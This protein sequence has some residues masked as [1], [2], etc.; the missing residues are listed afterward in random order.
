MS[1]WGI[2]RSFNVVM[3]AFWTSMLISSSDNSHFHPGS[4]KLLLW[5]HQ[6]QDYPQLIAHISKS[7][8]TADR[9]LNKGLPDLAM[10][11][12]VLLC[13]SKSIV[14]EFLY[15]T[16]AE[17]WKTVHAH[18]QQHLRNSIYPYFWPTFIYFAE[19][20]YNFVNRFSSSNLWREHSWS[21]LY[22]VVQLGHFP[23]RTG[24]FS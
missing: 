14:P 2:V 6:L 19:F 18:S 17:A 20:K 15:M 10:W 11:Q 13:F 23:V 12:Y 8:N 16:E 7:C 22:S 21:A 1:S 3:S 24:T 5:L 9:L 4:R